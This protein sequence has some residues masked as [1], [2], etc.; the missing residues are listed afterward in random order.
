MLLVKFTLDTVIY[1]ANSEWF[2]FRNETSTFIGFNSTNI[3]GQKLLPLQEMYD[4][5]RISFAYINKD[6]LQFGVLEFH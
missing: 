5:N 1:P 2:G 4:S 3:Y 6:H